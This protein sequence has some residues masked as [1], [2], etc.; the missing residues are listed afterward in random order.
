MAL[1]VA[2]AL[3]QRVK[4]AEPYALERR[5]VNWPKYG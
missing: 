4:Q 2:K 5:A 3:S 1:E